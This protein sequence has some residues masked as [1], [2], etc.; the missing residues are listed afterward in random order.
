MGSVS[1]DSLKNSFDSDA[2]DSSSEKGP[3]Y[4]TTPSIAII[5]R[6]NISN[7]LEDYPRKIIKSSR[8]KPISKTREELIFPF[9]VTCE[10]SF[11]SLGQG[12]FTKTEEAIPSIEKLP[13]IPEDKIPTIVFSKD[14]LAD[15]IAVLNYSVSRNSID[16]FNS[17]LSLRKTSLDSSASSRSS[18]DSSSSF[19]N[20]NGLSAAE[21]KVPTLMFSFEDDLTIDNNLSP[22]VFSKKSKNRPNLESGLSPLHCST[23]PLGQMS[24]PNDF[25]DTSK[26]NEFL[27]K[28]SR[29]HNRLRSIEATH[30]EITSEII[31]TITRQQ[32]LQNYQKTFLQT[33]DS[34]CS[35]EFLMKT[36][37]LPF[38]IIRISNHQFIAKFEKRKECIGSFVT[39]RNALL[40]NSITKVFTNVF[41]TSSCK[42]KEKD[43]LIEDRTPL[44]ISQKKIITY[45]KDNP[46]I[47]PCYYCEFNDSKLITISEEFDTDLY[48]FYKKYP[49]FDFKNVLEKI[50]EQIKIL[51]DANIIH[52]DIKPENIVVKIKDDKITDLKVIDFNLSEFSFQFDERRHKAC[53]PEY[54]S[55]E[56]CFD[57]P[58]TKK[59]D[60]W[61]LG[62]MVYE[63][64]H[65]K[66]QMLLSKKD[67]E[68]IKLY[69][70]SLDKKQESMFY[71]DRKIDNLPVEESYKSLLKKMLAFHAENRYNIDQCL[72]ALREINNKG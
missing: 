12:S 20:R 71:F 2:L 14:S 10:E 28:K 62:A 30:L 58:T 5:S 4:A 38:K 25:Y 22:R 50:F 47:L 51:H 55:P 34:W 43:Y 8:I 70:P 15:D 49:F 60:I 3:S 59:N 26:K 32:F 19:Y 6:L 23:K 13:T 17:N 11:I 57:R 44:L 31:I 61:T 45:L 68:T 46:N 63:L 7:L 29:K 41:Y 36:K 56:K 65:P 53:T 40:Y 1:S 9:S 35:G 27:K 66:H 72:K 42:E 18:R 37:R 69:Y 52:N 21:D 67:V 33:V 16:K 39:N 64:L 54:A 48:L 24:Q